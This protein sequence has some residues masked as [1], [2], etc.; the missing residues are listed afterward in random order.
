MH[1]LPP[2]SMNLSM[3][4]RVLL[5]EGRLAAA[6]NMYT[7]AKNYPFDAME[8]PW[9]KET[10]VLVR[11]VN[12]DSNV[13][14]SN[15]ASEFLQLRASRRTLLSPEEVEFER[16]REWEEGL[17]KY[18]ELVITRQAAISDVY[19]SVDLMSQDKDF[20]NFH[21]LEKF[22]SEQLNEA[23]NTQGRSGDTRFYYSG[24]AIAVLLDRLTP[25]WKPLALP[26]GK[27]LDELLQDVVK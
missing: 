2:W 25:A 13:K 20:H 10:D 15:L 19:R 23:K 8:E 4:I 24:Y 26:G 17:A 14:A 18:A 5:A 16:L 12:A 21:G 27:Y 6:E 11:A 3:P 7:V 22:W 1:I 9:K